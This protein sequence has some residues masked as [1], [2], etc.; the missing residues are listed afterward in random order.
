MNTDKKIN[1]F[2]DCYDIKHKTIHQYDK[3]IM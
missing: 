2:A 3:I 1:A